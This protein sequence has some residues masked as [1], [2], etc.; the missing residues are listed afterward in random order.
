MK[1]TLIYILPTNFQHE[2]IK[3]K[4]EGQLAYFN[5]VFK[6]KLVKLNYNKKKSIIFNIV[7]TI[8]FD[9]RSLFYLIIFKHF[10]VRYNPKSIILNYILFFLS[11]FKKITLEHNLNMANELSAM[12][13]LYELKLHDITLKLFKYSTIQHL[14]VNTEIQQH[15]I[16][17]GF[18]KKYICYHQNGY[19]QPKENIVTLS[20]NTIN[21]LQ[22][23]KKNYS[24]TA[25]FIGSGQ[26]WHGLDL[27][28]E[29]FLNKVDCSIIVIGPYPIKKSNQLY[30]IH[31]ANSA[32]IKEIIT[33]SDF[34]ISN[35]SWDMI[36]IQVGSPLKSRQYLCNG[37]PILTN[38]QDSA[39][40]ITQLKPFIYN[41]KTN[42]N[43]IKDILNHSHSKKL[44]QKEAQEHLSWK[45]VYKTL[46][47]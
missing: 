26:P 12:N 46:N 37:L 32:M 41:L 34:G 36:N 21:E 47:L 11:F 1:K 6:T 7:K 38:Y 22:S 33:F 29:L 8:S 3:I 35:F 18:S 10:F 30:H 42:S 43:A 27:I 31:S 20:K 17:L 24:K 39:E 28:L 5:T 45:S 4:V 13:R 19:L 23:F 2:G 40:D 9:M 44:I 14:C 15:L 25:I 16:D